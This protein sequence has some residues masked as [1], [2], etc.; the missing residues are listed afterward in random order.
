[1]QASNGGGTNQDRIVSGEVL[2][3]LEKRCFSFEEF[4]DI[5]GQ[6]GINQ[7]H[8]GVQIR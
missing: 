6:G 1:M 7:A 3:K 2:L 5:F 4:D 8:S